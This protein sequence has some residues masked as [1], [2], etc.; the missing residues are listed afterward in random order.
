MIN[1]IGSMPLQAAQAAPKQLF[2]QTGAS[3]LS[4]QFGGFLTEAMD[5]L[6]EQQARVNSLDQQFVTGQ[7]SDVH[8]LMI[9][10]E[11]ASL[12]LELTVQIRNK[13]VEAYQEIMRTQL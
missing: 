8:Q 3:E 4:K 5:K 11:K 2:A 7:T 9:A 13:A 1:G 12:G 10:T 6:N